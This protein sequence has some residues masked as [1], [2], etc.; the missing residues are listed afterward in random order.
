MLG[1]PD[2][3][4]GP[5]HAKA[6]HRQHRLPT[7]AVWHISIEGIQH[8]GGDARQVIPDPENVHT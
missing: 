3:R 6:N 4:P 1:D 5:I 2:N 8:V 7:H